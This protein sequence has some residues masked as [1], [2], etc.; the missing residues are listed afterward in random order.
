MPESTEKSRERKRR[1]READAAGELEAVA[2]SVRRL[3]RLD[4]AGRIA[5]AVLLRGQGMSTRQIA[6]R[7]GVCERAARY[8]IQGRACP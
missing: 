2:A 8:Y 4:R 7:I 6:L 5:L 3:A 1:A